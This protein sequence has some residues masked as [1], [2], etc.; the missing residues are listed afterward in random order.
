MA[1][2]VCCSLSLLS[3]SGELSSPSNTNWKCAAVFRPSSAGASNLRP[4]LRMWLRMAARAA[5][6]KILTLLKTL[7]FFFVITC[8]SVFNVWPKTTLLLLVW[9]RD[10]KRCDTPATVFHCVRETQCTVTGYTSVSSLE[11]YKE[12]YCNHC[13]TCVFVNAC[14]HFH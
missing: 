11:N 1:S 4:T 8:H 9:S 6:H 3:S 2:P 12:C 5:Q 14:M 13:S 10:T 7:Q